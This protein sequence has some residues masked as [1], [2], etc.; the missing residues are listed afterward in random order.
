MERLIKYQSRTF[1]F[2]EISAEFPGAKVNFG[3]FS[4]ELKNINAIAETAKA[5]DDFHYLM[6][7]DLSNTKLTKNLTKEDLRQ[8]T[9]ILLGA[10]ACILNFRSALEAFNKDPQNQGSSLDRSVA[11]MRNYVTSV[12][13]GFIS[14]EGRKA[15]LLNLSRL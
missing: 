12:T 10:H 5:L 1:E 6:C 9:K 14:E 11:I 7:N 13:P 15:Y 4:T 3:G 8:Y 2:K